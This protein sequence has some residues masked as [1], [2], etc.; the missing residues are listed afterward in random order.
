[1]PT[2]EELVLLLSIPSENLSIEYKSWLNLSDNADK[3]K[4]AKAAQ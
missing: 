1:M 4:L 3:A 2:T